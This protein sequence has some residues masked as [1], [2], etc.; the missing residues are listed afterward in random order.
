MSYLKNLSY[1]MRSAPRA[2]RQHY[3]PLKPKVTNLRDFL[4]SVIT[5][6]NKRTA[7]A[8]LSVTYSGTIALMYGAEDTL[9]LVSTDNTVYIA[10]NITALPNS[11]YIK[12]ITLLAIQNKLVRE[13]LPLDKAE[14]IELIASLNVSDTDSV[15]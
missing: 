12:M 2:K 13:A 14:L 7:Y 15:L 8:K 4:A 11:K 9:L 6:T 10:D 5:R 1:K 3:K